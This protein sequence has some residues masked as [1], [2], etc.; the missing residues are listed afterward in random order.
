MQ[1][2]CERFMR[3]ERKCILREHAGDSD[4][5]MHC[6]TKIEPIV[7]GRG[8]ARVYLD[9]T[10]AFVLYKAELREFAITEGAELHDA[11]YEKITE[12]VLP[13]R[14]KKRAM[15][16]LEKR[17]YTEKTLRDKLSD[18]EYPEAC[19][20][21]AI[22]YVKSYGYLDDLQY[23]IDHISYHLADRPRRRLEQDLLKKGIDKALLA[24]A[25][26]RCYE[27]AD[28]RAR[29]SGAQAQGAENARALER[30]M[31]EKELRKKR[32][33]PE[34]ADYETRAKLT[35]SLIRKGFDAEFVREVLGS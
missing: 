34:Q 5:P 13:L 10:F 16:L 21:A 30:N 1:R 31:I 7:N 4:R 24:Q 6:V 23:A 22:D 12:Q 18:G 3:T 33:D 15:H 29:E 2:D 8:R 25:F 26:E 19:I 28:L 14:A 20:D 35:A 27:E 17:P 32:Y 9:E 11:A